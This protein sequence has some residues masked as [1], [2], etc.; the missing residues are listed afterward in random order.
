MI[1]D[2]KFLI[3]AR[4]KPIPADHGYLLSSALTKVLETIHSMEGIGIHPITGIQTG[5]RGLLLTEASSLTIRIDA[6]RIAEILPLAGKTISLAGTNIQIG[7]PSIHVLTGVSVLRSRL[8]TIKGF[9][10][11]E[12]FRKSLRCHLD[13][14]GVSETVKIEIVKRRTL[15]IHDKNVVGFE[16]ILS[17]L[18]EGGS[19]RIQEEGLGG[20]RKMGCGIFLP[21]RS[22]LSGESSSRKGG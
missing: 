8:V 2:V 22:G 13:K 14:M 12:E 1:V 16:V 5:E 19:L 17:N 20:R 11:E 3:M 21:W 18:S 4:D 7:V 6:E 15:K 9:M 10:D